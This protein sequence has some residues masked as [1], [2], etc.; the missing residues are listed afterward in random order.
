MGDQLAPTV[1][2]GHRWDLGQRNRYCPDCGGFW[3]I[4]DKDDQP[5]QTC[6][7][8]GSMLLKNSKAMAATPYLLRERQLFWLVERLMLEVASASGHGD[9]ICC[10]TGQ[11]RAAWLHARSAGALQTTWALCGLLVMARAYLAD[12]TVPDL[13]ADHLVSLCAETEGFD[14]MGLPFFLAEAKGAADGHNDDCAIFADCFG[15]LARASE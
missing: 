8:P 7:G 2:I 6:P 10:L 4:D 1:S 13:D 14:P 12:P 3:L 15:D 5:P 9:N 11:A